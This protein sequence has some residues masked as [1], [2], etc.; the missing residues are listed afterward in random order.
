MIRGDNTAASRPFLRRVAWLASAGALWTLL[1]GQAWAQPAAPAPAE[2]ATPPDFWHQDTLTGDW[3]GL[4]GKLADSGVSFSMT[5]TGDLQ[6]N[7]GGGIQT[8]T[9]YNGL[10]QPAVDVDLDKLVGW[11]GGSLHVSMLQIS[12]PSLSAGYTGNLAN[13][14][15]INGRPATRLYNTWLQQTAFDN[16]LSVRVGV[17]TADTEFFTSQ[18]AS[19]FVNSSFGWPGVLALDLPGGGPGYPLPVPALRIAVSPTPELTLLAGVFGGDPTGHGGSNSLATQQPGGTVVS[20][21]GGVLSMAEADYAI[22]QGKEAKGL[23]ATFKVGAW[24]HSS[25]QFGDQ[26]F[27]TDGLSLAN[28]ASN[29]VPKNHHGDWGLYGIVDAMLYQLPDGE[30]R[31]L[32]AFL[33]VA[34]APGNQNLVTFYADG[35]LAYKGLCPQRPA[36][37]VGL[38]FAY[39]QIGSAARSL[40]VDTQSFGNVLFPVRNNET[41]VELSYQAQV[42][43]WWILQPDLQYVVNPNGGVDNADGTRRRNAVVV[44]LR[45]VVT[46]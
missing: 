15:S 20:F 25:D 34:D 5:Y 27:D 23:P 39:L 29:G 11:T 1:A 38:G 46:F 37:I 4:R 36:D 28:P 9:V 10:L 31:G 32:S 22:N 26:R 41:V 14:S 30:G 17:M 19:L 24:Y 45:T 40:D 16:L 7:V 33:R 18:T 8:G 44:T 43:P 2:D 42:T 6:S 21:R 13:V 3:G 35:G 12:G